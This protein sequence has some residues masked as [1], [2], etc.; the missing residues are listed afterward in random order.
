MTEESFTSS[1]NPSP[2]VRP[3]RPW[4]QYFLCA[5]VIGFC[6]AGLGDMFAFASPAVGETLTMLGSLPLTFGLLGWLVSLLWSRRLK[7]SGRPVYSD[8]RLRTLNF[9]LLAAA[10]LLIS[11]SLLIPAKHAAKGGAL[12]SR[13]SQFAASQAFLRGEPSG[14][15]T[16]RSGDGHL[17]VDVPLD[18]EA[19]KD[20]PVE[21]HALTV[22]SPN[23]EIGLRAWSEMK[24]DVAIQSLDAYVETLLGELGKELT[25]VEVLRRTTSSVPTAAYIEVEISAT[26]ENGRLMFLIR[27]TET[28]QNFIQARAWTAP[29]NYRDNAQ[30]IR[31]VVESVWQEPR[32]ESRATAKL[33]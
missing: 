14:R 19:A 20:F 27:F 8:P 32:E 31:A 21:Q 23:S 5:A 1:S 15:Q 29:S 33:H 10:I 2:L 18:W 28:S 6:L 3:A 26:V 7:R 24:E 9:S 16:L 11:L 13:E 12:A 22:V 25:Q 30:L 17:T 4:G